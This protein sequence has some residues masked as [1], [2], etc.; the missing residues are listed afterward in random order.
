MLLRGPGSEEPKL[1]DPIPLGKTKLSAGFAL[2][3]PEALVGGFKSVTDESLDF[4]VQPTAKRPA[5]IINP[6]FN[7]FCFM[8]TP[9]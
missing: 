4:F 9:P 7:D 2:V 5:R 8:E 6:N 3:S 1:E